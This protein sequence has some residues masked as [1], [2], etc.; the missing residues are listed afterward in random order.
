MNSILFN[1]SLCGF[2]RRGLRLYWGWQRACIWISRDKEAERIQVS[3]ARHR[4]SVKG[5]IGLS[6]RSG[7]LRDGQFH[8][9]WRVTPP[10]SIRICGTGRHCL[11]GI[12]GYNAVCSPIL[13][14]TGWEAVGRPKQNG[15]EAWRPGETGNKGTLRSG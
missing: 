4:E 8:C 12:C 3:L 11:L 2:E 10:R 14:P 9:L 13:N 7:S 15:E 1:E 5:E 6:I